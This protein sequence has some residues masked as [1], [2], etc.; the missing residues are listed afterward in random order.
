MNVQGH[1]LPPSRDAARPG[2]TR[3]GWIVL[4]ILPS[5]CVLIWAAGKLRP[6]WVLTDKAGAMSVWRKGNVTHTDANGDGRVDEEQI[7]AH[8]GKMTHVKRDQDFDGW[9]DLEYDLGRFG[10]ALNPRQI[11]ERAPKH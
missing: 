5:I 11:K 1:D 9:F 8:D 2:L 6:K 10:M 4:V 7:L 3:R